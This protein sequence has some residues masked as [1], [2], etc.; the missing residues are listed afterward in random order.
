MTESPSCKSNDSSVSHLP[1]STTCGFQLHPQRVG[2]ADAAHRGLCWT[3]GVLHLQVQKVCV[4]LENVFRRWRR[5][6]PA[7]GPLSGKSPGSTS[8]RR[9]AT[10]RSRK[11]SAQSV[12]KTSCPKWSTVSFP[13][14]KSS[15]RR[16]WRPGAEVGK[17]KRK[18]NPPKLKKVL[19]RVKVGFFYGL[20]QEFQTKTWIIEFVSVFL[21]WLL[22]S[23]NTISPCYVRAPHPCRKWTVPG[24]PENIASPNPFS[25]ACSECVCCGVLQLLLMSQGARVLLWNKNDWRLIEIFFQNQNFFFFVFCQRATFSDPKCLYECVCSKVIHLDWSAPAAQRKTLVWQVKFSLLQLTSPVMSPTIWSQQR[26]RLE[27]RG[28]GCYLTEVWRRSAAWHRCVLPQPLFPVTQRFIHFSAPQLFF[29]Q[30]LCVLADVKSS[31]GDLVTLLMCEKV[32]IYKKGTGFFFLLFISTVWLF[33]FETLQK[34]QW[35]PPKKYCRVSWEAQQYI[36]P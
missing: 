12:Q 26:D 4:E 6:W 25:T 20:W 18:K 33:G 11:W 7:I 29:F 36:S 2:H 31:S 9:T 17:K 28:W 14:P 23:L 3:G 1:F 21:L 32:F 22:F 16:S 35:Y 13:P 19:L 24:F 5:S 10:R 15:W 34:F 30:P 8:R 27:V